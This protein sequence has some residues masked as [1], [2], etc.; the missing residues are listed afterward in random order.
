[1]VPCARGGSPPRPRWRRSRDRLARVLAAPAAAYEPFRVE[2]RIVGWVTPAAG[3][4]TR[5]LAARCSSAPNAGSRARRGF[6][7]AEART[8]A[9]AE[10]ARSL[11]A[12]GALTAWR[13]ERYAVERRSRRQPPLFE[14]ERAAARYF[15]IHTFAAHAN[16]L[17]GA[18]RSVADVA[19]AAQRRPRRST[20][21][22]STIWSAA[23]SPPARRP[24]RRSSGKHGRRR[25]S[26]RTSRVRR[27]APDWSTSAATGPMDCSARR[28]M[29]TIFGCLRISCRRTRTA[30]PSITGS[31]CPRTCS[32]V[33]ATDD[34]TA[35]ASLVIVD[36]LLRHGHVA[37][38]DP[39]G[40][41]A[42]PAPS[43]CLARVQRLG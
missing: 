26:A 9:L 25:A 10:V 36:F 11:A 14:L 38:D 23:A 34:I 37:A 40:G 15:G 22:C 4:T 7:P 24:R 18:G 1:M 16:G 13:D 21:A 2:G 19:C 3:A 12:E 8:A 42:G 33:L 41:A 32:R 28:S 20:R 27:P 35:D 29:C 39:A 30:K 31:A 5:A 17:V 6:P 43:A